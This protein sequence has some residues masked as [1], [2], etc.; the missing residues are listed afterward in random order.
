MKIKINFFLLLITSLIPILH[1]SEKIKI[2]ILSQ[3]KLTE[4][5][6]KSEKGTYRILGGLRDS[7]YINE[8]TQL[9]IFKINDSLELFLEEK[10]IGKFTWIRL[11]A[12]KNENSFSIKPIKPDKKKR[13]YEDH[14]IIG[15]DKTNDCLRLINWVEVDKYIGGVVEAESGRKSHPEFYK[16]Q[17]ILARTYALSITG[18]H[19]AE[20]H[21]LCD[22]VHCQVFYGKTLERD[23]L[24]SV[25][26]TNNIVVVDKDFN[27]INAVFHS[28]SGGQTVNSEDLWGSQ[29]TYLRSVLDTFS[30][31]MP[32]YQWTRKMPFEDWLE[33]L[34]IKHKIIT[35]DS[36]IKIAASNFK[37]QK[38]LTNMDICG[39]KIPLK[40]IRSDLNLKSTY[41]DLALVN[42]T[43]IFSGKG[44]GHGIGMCQEGAMK[45]AKL[46]YD[47][48]TI[49]KFYYKGIQLINRQQLAF[50][51]EN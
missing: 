26:N 12:D 1:K 49:I 38:R 28:N 35:S 24:F 5:I 44:Y 3:Q 8:G 17:T 40:T 31:N 36:L 43:I 48:E 22:N 11:Y 39:K 7:F 23:I 37:Q 51:R 10:S 14:L 2:R 42:D 45:M 13:F 16:V 20:G 50:F 15:I 29:T 19:I 32:N 34:N 33:Y 21:D 41:F 9:K 27:L 30:L 6:F 25:T 46:G 18:R 4:C 47:Y